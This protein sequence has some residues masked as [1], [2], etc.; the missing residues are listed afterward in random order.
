MNPAIDSYEQSGASAQKAE[1][2]THIAAVFGASHG[3]LEAAKQLFGRLPVVICFLFA[4]G[5][6]FTWPQRPEQFPLGAL[7]GTVKLQGNPIGPAWLIFTP[8]GKAI[9]DHAVTIVDEKGQFRTDRL[10]VGDLQVRVKMPPSLRRRLETEGVSPQFLREIA[11][12]A[13]PLQC[14]CE[15]HLATVVDLELSKGMFGAR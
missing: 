1:I 14:R 12:I 3:R 6:D 9:G 10:A 4:A 8:L 7:S 5:C 2:A 15:A 13:S 11:G